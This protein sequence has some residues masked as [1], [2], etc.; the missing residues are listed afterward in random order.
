MHRRHTLQLHWSSEI[1]GVDIAMLSRSRG[2]GED[3]G[4]QK[5]ESHAA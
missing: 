3:R 4:G 1:A 2:E 5:D